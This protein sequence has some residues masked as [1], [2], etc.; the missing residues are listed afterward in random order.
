MKKKLGIIRNMRFIRES[1]PR[2]SALCMHNRN[3][4]LLNLDILRLDYN[5]TRGKK[6]LFVI[7]S[8]SFMD[9]KVGQFKL[10]VLKYMSHYKLH[11]I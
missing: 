3:L 7:Y 10:L 5:S 9:N 2:F 6:L 11:I 4:V 8:E 1:N